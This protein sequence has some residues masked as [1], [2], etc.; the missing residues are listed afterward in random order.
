M[1]CPTWFPEIAE[2]HV[3]NTLFGCHRL[4]PIA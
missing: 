1:I 3:Q 2:S 4:N